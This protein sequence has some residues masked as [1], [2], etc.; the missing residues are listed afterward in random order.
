LTY[1]LFSTNDYHNTNT[2]THTVLWVRGMEQYI[3]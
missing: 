2:H 1:L 3:I